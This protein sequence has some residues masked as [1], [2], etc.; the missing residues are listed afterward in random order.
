MKLLPMLGLILLV[1]FFYSVAFAQEAKTFQ[2][3]LYGGYSIGNGGMFKSFDEGATSREYSPGAAFGTYL[4]YQA[5]R[6]FAIQVA[7]NHQ[8][9]RNN[10][11][12]GS[13]EGKSSCHL[14]TLFLNGVV[15]ADLDQ[16]KCFYFLGGAGFVLAQSESLPTLSSFSFQAGA[17]MKV[18]LSE[19]HP[20]FRLV[21][22]GTLMFIPDKDEYEST[23]ANHVR[24][25]AGL[26]F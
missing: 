10:W 14:D 23:A 24:L 7:F 5:A 19:A 3:G 2:I 8:I 13:E 20:N 21:F 15:T 1:P 4:Q 25:Q 9:I 22:G 12:G 18:R 11:Y 16:S 17:G 6:P 26:E